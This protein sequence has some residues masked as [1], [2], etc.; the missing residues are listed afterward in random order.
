MRRTDGDTENGA[1]AE[2]VSSIISL[3]SHSSNILQKKKKKK[4]KKILLVAFQGRYFL[5]KSPDSSAP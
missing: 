1:I 2:V 5:Q 3:G 4:K